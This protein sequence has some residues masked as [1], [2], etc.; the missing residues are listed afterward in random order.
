MKILK[1]LQEYLDLTTSTLKRSTVEMHQRFIDTLGKC[2]NDLSI[3]SLKKI[4]FKTGYE[5][6]GWLKDNTRNKH[7]SIN[8]ILGYL[9]RVM[10][11]YQVESNFYAF[12]NLPK[13]TI[14]FERF[15]HEELEIIISYV[16]QMNH[17]RNSLVYRTLVL[18]LLDS[19]M[20]V[21]EALNV[22]ISDIDLYGQTILVTKSKTS[23][24]RYAPFSDFSSNCIKELIERDPSREILFYN[25]LKQRPITR[26]DV[27]LFYRWLSQKTGIEKIH[28][29][30]FRKTFGS[31]LAEKGMPIHYIQALYDHSR[32][33]TTMIYVNYKDTQAIASYREFGNKWL[34]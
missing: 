8:K 12:K 9:K 25:F 2:F 11:H 14:P 4:N 33:D 17:T 32:L 5:I 6:V 23:K 24:V 22:K 26:H 27:K 16:L 21:S 15:Y 30:R 19:G 29:H 20:R 7:N 34:S 3:K 31:I 1:T 18:L 13:D 10:K 28:S